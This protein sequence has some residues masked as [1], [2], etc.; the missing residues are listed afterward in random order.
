MLWAY[1]FLIGVLF[2]AIVTEAYEHYRGR[3]NG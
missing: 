1:S 2:G 3:E